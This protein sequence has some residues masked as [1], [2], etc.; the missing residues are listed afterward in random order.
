M[1]KILYVGVTV[2]LLLCLPLHAFYTIIITYLY[3]N[4]F[5]DENAVIKNIEQHVEKNKDN[6]KSKLCCDVSG[7]VYL[8]INDNYYL[9]TID[10]ND[11]LEFY[12]VNKNNLE[13]LEKM[14]N[15]EYQKIVDSDV[16][17]L[18]RKILEKME[19]ENNSENESDDEED[20]Q[21]YKQKMKYLQEDKYFLIE[22]EFGENNFENENFDFYKK[23]GTN[24][25]I[26]MNKG[27]SG[28]AIYD[29]YVRNENGDVFES[30]I[31]NNDNSY[32]ISFYKNLNTI[33]LNIIGSAIKKYNLIY[34]YDKNDIVISANKI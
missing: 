2:F 14:N 6:I 31:F 18:K 16:P 13:V 30:I 22:N 8:N 25:I 15:L 19:K 21:N 28:F 7:N 3:V 33:E 4:I 1:T 34:G 27:I 29:T 11:D 12:E 9:M 32:R 5:V 17:T 23:D 10:K 26:L 24:N 20:L